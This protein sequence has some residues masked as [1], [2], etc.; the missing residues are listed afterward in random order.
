MGKIIQVIEEHSGGTCYQTERLTLDDI[1]LPE[2]QDEGEIFNKR[3]VFE[4][5]NRA[6]EKIPLDINSSGKFPSLFTYF[7]D[8]SR[9]TYK[10]VDF[11]S[12]DGKFLPIV[13]G[14]V[15]TAVCQRHNKHLKKYLI[16]RE[17]MLAIPNRVGDEFDTIAQEIP[18]IRVPRNNPKSISISKVLKYEA[19]KTDRRFEDLAIAKI[20]V[21]ML[22]MEVKLINKMVKSNK[23][24]SNHMLM[25]DGSLQFSEV[26]D[27]TNFQHVV[28]V[29]K[30]FNPNIS[31][32]LKS[33]SNKE[34]G[35]YL[36]SLKFGER[37]PVFE[38][39]VE[40]N[41]RSNRNIKIG[42]WYLRIH[43]KDKVT[44]PL[45][46][47]IKVEKIATTNSEHEDGFETLMINEISRSILQERNVTCYGNDSRWAN[48]LYPIYL[49]ELFL[50]SH[51]ISDVFFLNLF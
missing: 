41:L 43:P 10:V 5:D 40:G 46:G 33:S 45:D 23:L 3:K 30:S 8:G 18:K 32:L 48:H 26:V 50:K 35:S 29:S 47:I 6:G 16:H 4:T 27:K 37:S 14:Q 49:T 51:F 11:G 39:E 36:T 7:L 22:S 44:R 9:R 19:D 42:A 2:Y 31:G 15:G 34:I 25:V 13:A 1:M 20:Q 24:T 21:E 12:T 17:N 28:G 38:Y